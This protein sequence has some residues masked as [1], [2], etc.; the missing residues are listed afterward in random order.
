MLW[1]FRHCLGL[2]G[3]IFGVGH[4]AE[5]IEDA[6]QR[7]RSFAEFE[8]SC[9]PL[10]ETLRTLRSISSLPL[11]EALLRRARED[12]H[13]VNQISLGLPS[14]ARVVASVC[15]RTPIGTRAKQ[16]FGEMR[17]QAGAWDR[18][19]NVAND[20]VG[21]GKCIHRRGRGVSQSLRTPVFPSAKLCALCGRS[22]LSPTEI[23]D[24]LLLIPAFPTEITAC[25]LD[26]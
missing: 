23:H 19:A 14:E 18:G 7:T 16:S 3:R 17:F 5:G 22:R 9:F 12:A 6:P 24:G 8:N 2:V 1:H 10:C 20:S 25:S 26:E 15:K 13:P 11:L 4:S 21:K